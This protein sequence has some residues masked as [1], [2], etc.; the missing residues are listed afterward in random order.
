MSDQQPGDSARLVGKLHA[1]RPDLALPGCECSTCVR[2]HAAGWDGLKMSSRERAILAAKRAIY[3]VEYLELDAV[4]QD[5]VERIVDAVLNV[6]RSPEATSITHGRHCF[7]SACARE[8]WTNPELA[9]CGMHGSS[10]P[11]VYAPFGRSGQALGG[12]AA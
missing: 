6:K 2:R 1:D 11:R 3:G 8:D 9:P 10:C 4:Q 7:C 5:F 12:V